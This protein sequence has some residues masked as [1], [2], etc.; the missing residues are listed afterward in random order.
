MNQVIDFSKV[1]T[2]VGTMRYGTLV[3]FWC[4][5]LDGGSTDSRII[6]IEFPNEETATDV[7]NAAAYKA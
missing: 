1:G 7:A 4:N 2:C 5:S 3:Q 6:T